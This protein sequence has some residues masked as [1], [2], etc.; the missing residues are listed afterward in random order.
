MAELMSCSKCGKKMSSNLKQCPH[1]GESR[2]STRLCILCGKSVEIS[3][4]KIEKFYHDSCFNS[5]R[6]TIA[7]QT[8]SC[9]TCHHTFSYGEL[10]KRK[11]MKHDCDYNSFKCSECG[12]EYEVIKK[13]VD[14]INE[15]IAI[16][17]TACQYCVDGCPK[18]IAIPNYFALYNTEKQSLPTAFSIQRV[19]Y[20][21]YSK[22]HGKASDC[23][24]CGLCEKSCPQHIAIREEL[25]RVDKALG[26]QN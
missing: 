9:Q 14:I 19:Y 20:D 22:V 6:E 4:E 15:A 18:E 17:C 12:E 23:I 8:F 21:N 13:A 24:A 7:N 25:V 26:Q 11:Y 10:D 5:H 1:C 3:V 2:T 16:P